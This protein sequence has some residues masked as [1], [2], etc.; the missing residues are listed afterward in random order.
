MSHL[1]VPKNKI[2]IVLLESIHDSAAE[3]FAAN[4]YGNVERIA[5][6]LDARDSPSCSPRRTSSASARAPS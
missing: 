3:L 5:G 4:G 2:R 6:S 1:S